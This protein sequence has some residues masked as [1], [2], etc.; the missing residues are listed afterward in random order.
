[1][2]SDEWEKWSVYYKE[3]QWAVPRRKRLKRRYLMIGIPALMVWCYV[4]SSVLFRSP[5]RHATIG[6]ALLPAFF[7][8]PHL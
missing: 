1:M 6:V 3:T 7:A 2:T 4:V 8:I 5:P